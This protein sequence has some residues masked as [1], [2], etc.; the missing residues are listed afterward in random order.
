M[1]FYLLPTGLFIAQG[2]NQ[3]MFLNSPGSSQVDPRFDA[4]LSC[5][6]SDTFDAWGN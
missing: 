5:Q 4:M 2:F 1:I 3:T 6:P